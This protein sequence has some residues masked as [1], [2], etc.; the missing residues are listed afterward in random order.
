MQ[1]GFSALVLILLLAVFASLALG[2]Y[3]FYNQQKLQ[4]INSFEEC[5]K[6]FP[7]M[8][9][10]PEQCNTPDGKH[11]VRELSE[12]EK[13]KL[14][15]AG[16]QEYKN[17]Q[18]RFALNI[19]PSAGICD[20]AKDV[21]S[22]YF[23]STEKC[24]SQ[25]VPNIDIYR[26]DREFSQMADPQVSGTQEE[27]LLNGFNAVKVTYRYTQDVPEQQFKAGDI[28]QSNFFLHNNDDWYLIVAYH[29]E[30]NSSD[31]STVERVLA[32]FKFTNSSPEV[33]Y[34]KNSHW[35]F[36]FEYGE[37]FMLEEP[38][39]VELPYEIVL[40]AADDQINITVDSEDAGTNYL[41]KS[42]TKVEI[43]Q[44]KWD[45]FPSTNYCD[46]G[47][48]GDT[49]VIY[50]IFNGHYRIR[51]SGRNSEGSNLKQVLDSFKILPDQ[52]YQKSPNNSNY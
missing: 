21:V 4:S 34:Y 3:Y 46:A 31:M 18:M 7:V 27:I 43:N 38:T 23:S 14:Q 45:Y 26:S 30:L 10:Y 42:P 50:Q 36:E 2:S 33:A 11:F 41:G 17:D 32:T 24:P 40:L 8:T 35:G 44:I 20:E 9:S 1:K 47:E 52:F 37:D 28:K 29:P 48:C 13:K 16:W 49:W 12:E 51:V 25:T 22:L 39:K 5:A 19:P 6:H 15:T